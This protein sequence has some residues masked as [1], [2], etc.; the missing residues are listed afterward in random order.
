MSW[1]RGFVDVSSMGA[2]TPLF[3]YLPFQSFFLFLEELQEAS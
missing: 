2:S 3:M 1:P